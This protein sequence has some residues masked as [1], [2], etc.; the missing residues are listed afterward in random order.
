MEYDLLYEIILINNRN[1]SQKLKFISLDLLRILK[2][3]NRNPFLLSILLPN[4]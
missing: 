1:F 3:F 4:D 2:K